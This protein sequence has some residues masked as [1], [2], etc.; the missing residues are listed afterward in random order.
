MAENIKQIGNRLRGLREV[1]D[2][3]V[4]QMAEV[5][6]T[7]LDHYLRIE[8]GESDPSVYRLTKVSK[9]FGIALDVLLFGEEPRMNGYFVTRRGQGLKVERS[10]NYEYES[11]ASGFKGRSVEPF[12]TVIAPLADGHRRSQNAHD[13]HEFNYILEGSMEL[14]IDDKTLV[15][16]PGDSIYFDASHPHCMHAVGTTPVK[17]LVVV[18]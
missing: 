11:L 16:N 13:G 2:I 6:E 1:L 8:A 5:M 18:I 17:M 3:P 15:L 10:D 9:R 4:E 14:C 7:S 12:L